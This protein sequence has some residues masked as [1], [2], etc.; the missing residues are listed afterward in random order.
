MKKIFSLFFILSLTITLISTFIISCDNGDHDDD[1]NNNVNNDAAI[2][3]NKA[4]AIFS[5]VF[6]YVDNSMK[7]M[8]DSISGKK[9]GTVMANCPTV[10]ITPF[11]TVNWPKVLTVDFGTNNC[12][13]QDGK[14]RRG[15][16]LSSFTGWYRDSLTVVTITFDAYHVNDDSI[17]GTKTITNNGHNANGNL[18]FDVEVINA[19]ITN[20]NGTSSWN[21][22]R[23]NE[24]IQ[25]ENTPWPFILDDI[26]LI[27]GSASGITKA[28]T[29]YAV[30][31]TSPLRV[32]IGCRWIVS[33]SLT[34]T[35]QLVSPWLIDYGSGACD[36]N[37]TLTINGITF[38]IQLY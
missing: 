26:Y 34:L 33:G 12:L 21:S 5:D 23:N 29:S 35:P 24:W 28:G 10:S 13:C 25:G 3:N 17:S 19:A 31:I 16:I 11:D 15:K 8:E 6:K 38:N 18:N 37:A 2:E 4:E 22:S 14:Y 9:S 32:E 7:S 1:N 20:S 27:S 36:N 30:S